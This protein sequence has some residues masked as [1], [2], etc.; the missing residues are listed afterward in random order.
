MKPGSFTQIYIQLIFAVKFRECL[1]H[2]NHRNQLF[3]YISGIVKNL[4][5]KPIIVNGFSDHAH[6][7]FGLN[8]SISI[9]DTVSEIKNLRLFGSTKTNGFKVHSDGRMVIALYH[10]AN[11]R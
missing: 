3:G 11:L 9:S 2:I 8:P 1:L 7:F 10:I 6:I 4:N 5:H